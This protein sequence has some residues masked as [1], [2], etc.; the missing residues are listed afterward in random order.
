MKKVFL[1]SVV[2]FFIVSCGNKLVKNEGIISVKNGKGEDCKISYICKGCEE[3]GIEKEAFDSVSVYITKETRNGLKYPLSFVPVKFSITVEKKDSVYYYD[4]NEK[5]ENLHTVD[6][7]YDYIAKNAY[8]NELEGNETGIVYLI[9]G[10]PADLSDKIRLDSLS[11]IYEKDELCILNRSLFISDGDDEYIHITPYIRSV[12]KKYMGYF[13][14]KKGDVF[15][16][17]KSSYTCVDKDA[18][19]KF[20]LDNGEKLIF[21][22]Q[23]DYN[24]DGKAYYVLSKGDVSK[25]KNNKLRFVFMYYKKTIGSYVAYNKTDYFQQLAKIVEEL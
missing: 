24:C 11:I 19:L 22:S 14:G 4:T 8:G 13:I 7:S 10:L 12:D 2:V 6:Y 21:Q 25:F 5:I 20:E 18:E 17:I 9:N 15:L 3:N 16:Q 1:L 23:N